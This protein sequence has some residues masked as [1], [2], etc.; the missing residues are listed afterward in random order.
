M[1]ATPP[2]SVVPILYYPCLDDLSLSFPRSGD[3]RYNGFFTC[4][5]GE[6]RA[7]ALPLGLH[8]SFF[9]VIALLCF[10]MYVLYVPP[11]SNLGK[12]FLPLRRIKLASTPSTAPQSGSERGFFPDGEDDAFVY[13]PWR[14]LLIHLF[15]MYVQSKQ[16]QV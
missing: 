13:V 6:L 4:Q 5:S 10:N 15:D 3:S 2:F 9:P 7:E 1:I 11:F 12:S 14:S 16:D 8:S